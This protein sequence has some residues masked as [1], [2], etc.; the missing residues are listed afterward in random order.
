LIIN[1]AKPFREAMSE[2][3]APEHYPF[4][5]TK[6]LMNQ[7]GCADD[8]TPRKCVQRCRNKLRSLATTAG[9]PPPTI[10]AVLENIQWHGYRLNPNRVKIVARS[11]IRVV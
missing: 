10:D 6:V 2:E 7:I 11:E 8:E 5:A 3:R 4:T 1:L 9:D